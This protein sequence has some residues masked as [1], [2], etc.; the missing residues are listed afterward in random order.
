MSRVPGGGREPGGLP[1]Q[2]GGP[3]H[4]ARGR[5]STEL[6]PQTP[7]SLLRV[8]SL[9]ECPLPVPDLPGDVFFYPAMKRQEQVRPFYCDG[10]LGC[11]GHRARSP[12]P[13]AVSQLW[14]SLQTPV[15]VPPGCQGS[16]SVEHPLPP[17]TWLTPVSFP[18]SPHVEWSPGSGRQP[19]IS[20]SGACEVGRGPTPAHWSSPAR[21]ALHKE[22]G[23][24]QCD[25]TARGLGLGR[26][27]QEEAT[28]QD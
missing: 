9:R 25:H 4:A 5:G 11:R 12:C 10:K 27:S 13:A 24:T 22:S 28:P 8:G 23:Q 1:S 15:P 20:G 18:M 19:S 7:G 17:E 16:C 2:T 6:R 26:R 21:L 14:T 3:V